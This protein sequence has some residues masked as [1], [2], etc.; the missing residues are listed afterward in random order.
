MHFS[1]LTA[2]MLAAC[3]T[4]LVS[5]YPAYP[6]PPANFNSAYDEDS[7]GGS[8]PQQP[9]PQGQPPQRYV[10]DPALVVAGVAA[11]GILGYAIGNNHGYHHHSYYGPVC[12]GPA[13]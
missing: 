11:A 2:A 13:R 4:L 10:V 9:V 1:R 6:P 3:I 12:Y 8:I 7:K 5:C